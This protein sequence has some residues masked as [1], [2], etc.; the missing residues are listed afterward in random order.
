MNPASRSMSTVLLAAMCFLM[1]IRDV[2]FLSLRA[3]MASLTMVATGG[4]VGT[5]L[6]LVVWAVAAVE[7][8]MSNVGRRSLKLVDVH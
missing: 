4:W 1:A 2:P 3:V 7:D 5:A 6:G 8:M